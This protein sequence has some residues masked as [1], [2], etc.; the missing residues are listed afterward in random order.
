M[1]LVEYLLIFGMSHYV[2]RNLLLRIMEKL[3]EC[4]ILQGVRAKIALNVK[5][6]FELDFIIEKSS[7]N[8]DVDKV[9]VSV[10][11]CASGNFNY[12]NVE[13]YQWE[14]QSPAKVMAV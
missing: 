1:A 4:A 10:G 6:I 2:D 11:I 13:D 5:G 9:E 3:Y 8:V 14:L 12:E 7:D